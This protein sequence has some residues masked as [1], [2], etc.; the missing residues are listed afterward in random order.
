MGTFK[1]GKYIPDVDDLREEL[2]NNPM[3]GSVFGHS[4]QV[5]DVDLADKINEIIKSLN[6]IE[7]RVLRIE[8]RE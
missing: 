1:N 6:H 5:S 2:K 7:K 8:M 4:H 3:F